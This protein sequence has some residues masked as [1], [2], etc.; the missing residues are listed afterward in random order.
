MLR[1]N[2]EGTLVG[3]TSP[4]FFEPKGEKVGEGEREGERG[5]MRERGRIRER[6]GRETW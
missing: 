2:V 6:E 4:S 1:K 3:V 5:R